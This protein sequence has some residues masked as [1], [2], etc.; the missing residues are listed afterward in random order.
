MHFFETEHDGTLGTNNN[1]I[2]IQKN[3]LGQNYP[4]PV[5]NSTTIPFYL[6][7]T[8]KVSIKLY[9]SEGKLIKE[10]ANKT[11]VSGN[12]SIIFDTA[13]LAPGIYFYQLTAGKFKQARKMII[14]R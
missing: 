13:A 14:A 11:F 8:E 2:V 9:S 4:N 3:K 7:K 5:I 6:L 10:I 1:E 12:N